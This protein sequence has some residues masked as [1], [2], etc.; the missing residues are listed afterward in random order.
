MMTVS[1]IATKL[2]NTTC[3]NTP[4]INTCYTTK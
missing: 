1:R 2:T 3:F 4:H